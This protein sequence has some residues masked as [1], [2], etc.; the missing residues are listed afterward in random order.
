MENITQRHD[1]KKK[2]AIKDFLPYLTLLQELGLYEKSYQTCYFLGGVFQQDT[3]RRK[4]KDFL[5][6]SPKSP[7]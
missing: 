5:K 3:D 4:L 6:N 1:L 2:Y 7:E